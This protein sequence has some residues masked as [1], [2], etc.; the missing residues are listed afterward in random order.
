MERNQELEAIVD[1]GVARSRFRRASRETIPN[2]SRQRSNPSGSVHGTS[3]RMV[4][5]DK[6]LCGYEWRYKGK[7]TQPTCPSCTRKISRSSIKFGEEDSIKVGVLYSSV[8]DIQ[9]DVGS[10]LNATE[11]AIGEINNSNLL[12][13]RIEPVYRNGISDGETFGKM[14]QEFVDEGVSSIFGFFTSDIRKVVNGVLET[15]ARAGKPNLLWYSPN[16]EGYEQSRD[17]IHTGLTNNQ[18]IIPAVEWW[19]RQWSD[20]LKPKALLV[21]SDYVFSRSANWTINLNPSGMEYEL[22][23]NDNEQDGAFYKELG[24]TNFDDVI[25]AIKDNMQEGQDNMIFNTLNANSNI[26]FFKQLINAGINSKQAPVMSFSMTERIISCIGL[27]VMQGHFIAGSYFNAVD[28]PENDRIKRNYVTRYGPGA[29]IIDD[30]TEAAYVQM[31]LFANT[32]RKAGSIKPEDIREAARGLRYQAPGGQVYID[33]DNL[34][35]WKIAR[36]GQINQEG[37]IGS[38]DIKWDSVHM[39]YPDSYMRGNPVLH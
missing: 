22:I 33:P 10:L 2:Y 15:N 35:L 16:Y 14:T 24:G 36:I 8:Y 4:T 17:I 9:L 25:K 18:Q 31:H 1:S 5:C 30:A 29:G 11:F 37:K 32:V 3:G 21:G 28:T 39:M 6:P 13:R 19:T 7:A 26:A 27:D 20:D 23:R 12:G 34:H 38:G